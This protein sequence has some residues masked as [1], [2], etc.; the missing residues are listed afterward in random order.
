MNEYTMTSGQKRTAVIF[1]AVILCFS[2]LFLRIFLVATGDNLQT[3]AKSQSSYTLTVDESRGTIYDCNL[4]PMVNREDSYVLSILPCDEAAAAV[5]STLPPEEGVKAL[6]LF[7]SGKPFLQRADTPYIYAK[8]IDV[9]TVKNRYA[10]TQPAAHIIGHLDSEGRGAMGIEK[11]YDD[12]LTGNSGKLSITYTVDALRHPLANVT[13][14]ITREGYENPQG[15]VL[16]LDRE[17]QLIAEEEGARLIKKGAV[18]IME[19]TTGKIRAAASFPAFS[20]TDLAVSLND[21]NAPLVN[22]CFAAYN[23]GST[24]KLSGLA[25]ALEAGIPTDYT[26]TCVGRI[27]A[28]PLAFFCHNRAGHG[29]L[30]MNGALEH[31]CNPYFINLGRE[32][33]Y[34][35]LYEMAV[36]MGFGRAD[37]LGQGIKT[38]SGTLPTMESLQN[39]A[40]LAN[41]SFGQGELTATPIQIAKLIAVF[42][43]GG[44]MVYPSI[45]E[46]VTDA[47]GTQVETPYERPEA[48]QVVPQGIAE[49]VRE[50]MV[51]VVDKGSGTNAQPIKNGAGGK[52]GSAQTGV[53]E[54]D[55]EIVHAWFSGFFPAENP[56]YVIVVLNEGMDSGGDYSAPVFK[57]IADRVQNLEARRAEGKQS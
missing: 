29:E 13:P 30:D 50:M 4:K 16:T 38:A 40:V 31:S 37:E 17:M 53:Y 51:N 52:T 24:F 55:K 36:R 5:A 42:A 20:P 11:A 44:R 2:L 3:V 34:D 33:G 21:E 15:V 9:F 6:N 27:D 18:I 12:L 14:E 46:G 39:L 56:K 28:G 8:G 48:Y 47:N 10:K 35:K 32:T 19:A 43:N 1:T 22:R 25:A 57:E 7:E 45:V 49:T 54:G 41:F 23:V 26:Y